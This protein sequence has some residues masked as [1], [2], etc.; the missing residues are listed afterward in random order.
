MNLDPL[1]IDSAIDDIRAALRH[2]RAV[3]VVAEPGAGKTTRV[4]PALL[5]AGKAIVLQPR[6]AAAR[7]IARRIADEHGWRVGREVGWQIRFERRF[8]A[9]TRLLIATEGVLTARL[10]HD[11]LLTGFSTIVLDEFHER[12]VHADLAIA[13]ARQAMLAR[14]DLRLVVMSA[15]MDA[16]RVAAFLSC[17]TIV[18]PGRT[19]PVHVSYEPH[20]KVS[21]AVAMS[22][23]RTTGTILCFQPGA[24]EIERTLSELNDAQIDRRALV[25]PLHGTLSADRQ[26]AALSGDGPVRRV[27]V[28]TNIAETS[29]TVPG[30]TAVVDTG[31]EKLARYDP[32]LAIDSLRT[33]RISQAA[34]DQRAG[35]AG[36]T[37]PGVVVRLWNAADRLKPFREPE[38]HR[39]DLSGVVLDIA[40]WGGDPRTLEWFEAPRPEAI[41][42]AIALLNR[43]QALKGIA[44][45]GIGRAMLRL[46]LPP[47][48]AR[49]V[50]EADGHPD[51]VRVAALLA[52]R[53]TFTWSNASTSSDLLSAL[54]RWSDVP[55]PLRAYAEQL[56]QATDGQTRAA[57][58]RLDES[59][60]RRAILAG[61]P[62]RVA[63]RRGSNSPRFLLSTGTGAVLTG[64]SG[65]RDADFIVALDVQA[66][67][68]SADSESRIRLAS[69]IER[70]WL[71][72]TGKEVEHVVDERGVV[73]ATETVRYDAIALRQ[74]PVAV[75]AQ[76][77]SELLAS[78]WLARPRSDAERILLNRLRFAGVPLDLPQLLGAAAAGKRSVDEIVLDDALPYDVL[79]QLERDAPATLLLPSGRHARL[80]YSDGGTVGASVKLQELFGLAETPRIGSRR[81]P[82]LL[83]LRAPNGRAVQV[84]R[85]L[86]SFWDRTYPEVRKEL[87]GRYPKHPWP[88]DPWSA[89]PTHRAKTR[90]GG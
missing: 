11:P 4:P 37:A 19:Y 29:V 63:Q 50:V 39:V 81:E 54:D 41:G 45:T 88:E 60:F 5:D 42:S 2:T 14:D 48:L 23:E 22:L 78:A 21:Q 84:T 40:G 75:D 34:A 3:V 18:V 30:V 80:D 51:A 28:C 68:S 82:L 70:E 24:R 12:S 86:R 87:R 38:L 90:R 69:A 66:P 16:E 17:A 85:D 53:H 7:A 44:I 8:Q 58:P 10:Q 52:E 13:L 35:R 74:R 31:L 64:Q 15:T 32:A 67:S 27:V 59:A 73:R 79:R 56:Q 1:P 71:E 76:R 46:P 25:L 6:R 9:D 47:R 26:D 77:A 57:P 49:I 65:V 36:R 55:S 83:E 61:Y 72:P 33:E 20:L 62:D 43:M 89:V